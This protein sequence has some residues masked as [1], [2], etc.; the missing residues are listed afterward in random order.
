GARLARDM[1]ECNSRLDRGAFIAGKRAPTG[2]KEF[3][4]GS[5]SFLEGNRI[6]FNS[7]TAYPIPP[8]HRW[9]PSPAMA[10]YGQWNHAILAYN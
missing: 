5:Y 2:E 4:S 8:A 7:R 9:N 1:A 6:H 10:R 3:Q